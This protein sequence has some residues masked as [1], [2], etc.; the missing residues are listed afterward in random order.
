ME[1]RQCLGVGARLQKNGTSQLWKEQ[2]EGRQD[3][4]MEG[5]RL[6]GQELGRQELL[7]GRE[8]VLRFGSPRLSGFILFSEKQLKGEKNVS[9]NEPTLQQCST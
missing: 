3:L 6:L 8:S 1:E 2:Q 9:S 5:R 4:G 7:R